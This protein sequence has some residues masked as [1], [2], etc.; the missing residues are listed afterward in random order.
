M[1]HRNRN[2]KFSEPDSAASIN[3]KELKELVGTEIKLTNTI[4]IL[5][6]TK[7]KLGVNLPINRFPSQMKIPLDQPN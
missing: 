3:L 4:I 7:R 1:S 6:E 2:A 5:N